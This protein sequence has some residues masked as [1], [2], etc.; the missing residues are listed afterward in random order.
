MR[1]PF[2]QLSLLLA[3]AAVLATAPWQLAHGAGECGSTPPDQMALKLAPCA[4]A[5]EDPGA[6]PSGGC[7]AAVR[8]IGKHQS[9]ACLCAVLLSN[10]VRHSGVQPEVAITI[11]KRCNLA[12]RPVGYKCGD[13]TLPSLQD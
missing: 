11:P 2:L 13:Y 9:A 3:A 7:C 10:T 1:S 8:D 12:N 5:A 6:A 4:S